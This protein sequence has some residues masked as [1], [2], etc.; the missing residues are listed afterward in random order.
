M[1]LD[2]RLHSSPFICIA[3]PPLGQ[4]PRELPRM[5]RLPLIEVASRVSVIC[6]FMSASSPLLPVPQLGVTEGQE[7]P[8]SATS[9]MH[10]VGQG[11]GGGG[12]R[13]ATPTTTPASTKKR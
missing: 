4:T 5:G 2:V 11:G 1:P 3:L 7:G 8:P 9:S 6:S 10:S 13:T 12:E